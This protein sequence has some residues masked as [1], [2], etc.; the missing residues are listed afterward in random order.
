MLNMNG[1]IKPEKKLV[2]FLQFWIIRVMMMKIG[3]KLKGLKKKKSILLQRWQ[4]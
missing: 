3:P 1:P 2:G 4:Q